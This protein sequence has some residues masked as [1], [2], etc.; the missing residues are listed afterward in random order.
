[1]EKAVLLLGL[2]VGEI[3]APIPEANEHNLAVGVSLSVFQ[4]S[5]L[6]AVVNKYSGKQ[7][8][9]LAPNFMQKAWFEFSSCFPE[10]V[11]VPF[12]TVQNAC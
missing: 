6:F 12:S 11:E 3:T 4:E 2:A 10:E 9:N 1:M 7:V 5:S 8:V